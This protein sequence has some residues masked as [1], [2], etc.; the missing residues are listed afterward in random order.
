[1]YIKLLLANGHG[2]EGYLFLNKKYIIYT[3]INYNNENR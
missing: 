2:D 1:M 3:N